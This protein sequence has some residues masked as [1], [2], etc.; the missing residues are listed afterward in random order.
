MKEDK[1]SFW[2]MLGRSREAK[3]DIPVGCYIIAIK[4]TI[5]RFDS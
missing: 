3:R 5:S 4:L 2:V 1:Q